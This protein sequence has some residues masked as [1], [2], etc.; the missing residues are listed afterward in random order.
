MRVTPAITAVRRNVMPV[1][2]PRQAQAVVLPVRREHILRPVR[3]VVRAVLPK[4]I[5]EQELA[6]VRH[7]RTN[8]VR[9]K[10]ADVAVPKT[11]RQPAMQQTV[12]G[13]PVIGVPV[14]AKA[15]T[16]PVMPRAKV[17]VA[18]VHNIVITTACP[19]GAAG[20][21]VTAKAITIPVTIRAKVAV[22]AVRNI[23]ITT[24]CPDGAAG[25]VAPVR[26]TTQLLPKAAV[27]AEA[28]PTIA[29]AVGE[30]A[31]TPVAQADIVA[32]MAVA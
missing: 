11:E 9:H 30:V 5:R 2:M 4:H 31:L 14:T 23:V 3:Q 7:V 8:R 12:H 27:A 24:A 6:V 18:A 15:I 25:A 10:A 17:A 26:A 1:N 29:K 22:A 20:A 32:P 13:Q 28:R 16:I 21:L 19:D